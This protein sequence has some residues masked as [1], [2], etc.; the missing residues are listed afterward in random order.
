MSAP[1]IPVNILIGDRTYRIKIAAGDEEHVRRT[2]KLINEKVIEF[3]TQFSGQDMQDYVAMVLVWY[4]TQ[5]GGGTPVGI[6]ESSLQKELAALE[7]Q[8]DKAIS[9]GESFHF[10][11]AP[12]RLPPE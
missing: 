9:M 4:A 2:I 10:E 12:R 7:E 1:L 5:V 3:K 6:V 8:L 11:P